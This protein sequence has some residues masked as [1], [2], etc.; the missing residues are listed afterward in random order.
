MDS[1]EIQILFNFDRSK[2]GFSEH[3]KFEIKYVC[4][5]FEERNKLLHRNFFIFKMDF[6]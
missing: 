4:K 5:G 6:N 1:N 2:K 3:E